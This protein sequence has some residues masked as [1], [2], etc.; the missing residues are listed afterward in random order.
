MMA[1]YRAIP[2]GFMTVG[3]VA[4]K[5]GVTVRTLQYYDKEGLPCLTVLA[6]R[7]SKHLV[8]FNKKINIL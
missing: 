5:M 8:I 1:K 4:K 3:E 6:F 2:E 7:I